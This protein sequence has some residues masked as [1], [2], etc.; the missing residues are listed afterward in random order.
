MPSDENLSGLSFT[1]EDWIKL[2]VVASI[3]EP[4][5]DATNY[6]SQSKYSTL[7]STLFIYGVLI[8]VSLINEIYIQIYFNFVKI[9]PDTK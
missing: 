5:Y 1:R 2:K 8:K 7:G 9:T 6:L 4:L 3:L